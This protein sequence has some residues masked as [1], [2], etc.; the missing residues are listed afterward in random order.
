LLKLQ[1]KTNTRRSS[2]KIFKRSEKGL[3]SRSFADF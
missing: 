3:N 1:I 2:I